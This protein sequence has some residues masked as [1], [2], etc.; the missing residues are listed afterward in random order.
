MH[1]LQTEIVVAIF[2]DEPVAEGH[3]LADEPGEQRQACNPQRVSGGRCGL[4]LRKI[5]HDS[6]CAGTSQRVNN[7]STGHR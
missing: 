4:L 1:A 5:D 6:V 7:I 3:R 2:S